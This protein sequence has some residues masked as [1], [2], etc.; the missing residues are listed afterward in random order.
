MKNTRIA[1]NIPALILAAALALLVGASPARAEEPP[2]AGVCAKVRLEIQQELAFERV[3]FEGRLKVSNDSGVDL[4]DILVELYV[5]N[6]AGDTPT[7]PAFFIQDPKV[8][9]TMSGLPDGSGIIP[10]GASARVTWL[11]IPAYYAGGTNPQGEDYYIGGSL[12]ATA[13]DALTSYPLFPDRITVLPQPKLDID[14]FLP[15]DVMAD[16]P[17]T[18]DQ[19]EEPI[20]FDLGVRIKNVGYGPAN[21]MTLSSGQP[22]IVE[23]EKG[24]LIAFRL[25]AAYIQNDPEPN[26]SLTM[27]FGNVPGQETRIGRWQMVSTL[28]GKFTEFEATYKHST[29]LGGELTSLIASLDT[30]FLTHTMLINEPGFDDVPDFLADTTKKDAEITPDQIFSSEGQEFP[31]NFVAGST[32]GV[33]TAENPS[34]P[35]TLANP[36]SGWVYTR[37]L[38]PSQGLLA[39]TG[40]TRSD[41]KRILVPQNSWVTKKIIRKLGQP[42]RT[43]FTLH[44]VDLNSTGQYS[45]TFEPPPPDDT[46]PVT[47]PIVQEP[48]YGQDPLYYGT[49]KT[50]VFLFAQDDVS[51]VVNTLWSING[52]PLAPAYPITFPNEGNYDFEYYSVDRAGNAEESK[53]FR[54][55]V[56][57]SA[58]VIEKLAA[59]AEFLPALNPRGED[60]LFLIDSL[61]RD[62]ATPVVDLTLDVAQGNA[63]TPEGFAA[64]PGVFQAKTRVSSGA[65]HFFTW[66]G[67]KNGTGWIVAPGAYTARLTAA[68]PLGHSTTRLLNFQV[69]EPYPT[70]ALDAAGNG[71]QWYPD[72]DGPIAVWQDNRAGNWDVYVYDFAT[73]TSRPIVIHSADQQ[74]PRVSGRRIVFQ[75][76]RSGNQDVYLFDLDT[77]TARLL[78]GGAGDQKTPDIDGNYVVYA[79]NQNGNDDLYLTNI[80]DGVTTP[81]VTNTSVQANPRIQGGLIVFDDFRTGL[82]DVYVYDI[83]ARTETRL[84]TELEDQ[85]EADVY[86]GRIVWT[87]KRSGERRIW[88]QQWPAGTAAPLVTGAA[89][90]AEPDAARGLTAFTDYTAAS[91]DPNIAVSYEGLGRI[92]TITSDPSSQRRPALDLF[93]LLWQDDRGGLTRIRYAE[94]DYPIADAGP[95]QLASSN[96]IVRLDGSNSFDPLGGTLTYLWTQAAGATVTLNGA[97][98]AT[99]EFVCPEV[100]ST[101]EFIFTLVVTNARHASAPDTVIVQVRPRNQPPVASAGPDRNVVGLQSVTI[102]GSGSADP[103]NDTII[104]KWTILQPANPGFTLNLANPFKPTFRAPD[105]TTPTLVIVRLVVNDGQFDSLP[106]DVQIAID[107]RVNQPPV[108]RVGADLLLN[109]REIVTLDGSG[110]YDPEGLP[111]TYEWTQLSGPAVTLSNPAVA[112]PTF[113]A[114]NVARL[115][116]LK[117]QLIVHDESVASAPV[118]QTVDVL[119]VRG[120]PVADAG[121]AVLAV[122]EGATVTLDGGAS[123]H[124]DSLPITFYWSQTSGPAVAL[125]NPNAVIQAFRAPIQRR[126]YA[127]KFQLV[128]S[129]DLQSSL[130]D[131]VTVNVHSNNRAPVADAGDDRTTDTF[132]KV[133]LNG[134]RSADPDGDAIT[135]QWRQVSGPAVTLAGANTFN[136]SFNTGKSYTGQQF[137]FEL[138]VSDGAYSATDRVTITVQ[139]APRNLL[140]VR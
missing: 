36:P 90:Q 4:K 17:F 99:P 75:D 12:Y 43:E 14:Y 108:A 22:K 128:V 51:G 78:A 59:D 132:T 92:V 69:T 73:S 64:L 126:D 124:P 52:S 70:Q 130:P 81:I 137:V 138:T 88:S 119:D 54:L 16:D 33:P 37:V 48:F 61:A 118:V 122:D 60:A 115:E 31:V 34:V 139:L 82:S 35:L 53:T 102:D 93:R 24:L 100:T 84:T 120:V 20:P 32:T 2:D 114:P 79:S 7:S 107:P 121:P 111:I 113:T 46:P 135:Y 26:P 101:E 72:I 6:S 76:N 5:F 19:I 91:G 8:E 39:L 71:L 87:D 3:A 41:G 28:M 13:N 25:L 74:R 44:L 21:K 65:E 9:G 63:T 55:V 57:K 47:R 29:Q 133:T 40:V 136:P 83:A 45:V 103:D 89:E 112:R 18:L 67:R 62:N 42:E 129:D 56:D 104:P 85:R 94:V 131:S 134:S 50:E 123:Y 23:N 30:N 97:D 95:D 110:S 127:M 49:E 106:D 80:A 105:V 77:G 109:E 66:N 125:A 27:V 1:Y 98:T 140:I 86:D 38:D 11:F 10:A 58:P 96:I 116:T 15:R 68:D 117:F